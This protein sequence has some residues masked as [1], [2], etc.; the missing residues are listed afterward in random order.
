MF[1]KMGKY[2]PVGLFSITHI[3]SIVIC[4]FLICLV[5]YFTRNMNKKTFSKVLLVTAILLTFLEIFK[6][7]WSFINGYSTTVNSWVPLYFCSLFIYSLWLSQ[8]KNQFIKDIGMSY[9]AFASFI[10]GLVFIFMPTSSFNSYPI[11]H[12]QCLYSMLYHSLMVYCGLMIFVTKSVKINLKLVAKYFIFCF[13]FMIIALIVNFYAGGNLMFISNPAGI[14]LKFLNDI[15]NY[16]PILYTIIM[17]AVHM[18][19]G[20]LIW[21]IN[22]LFDKNPTLTENQT[23]N[24]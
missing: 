13:I 9:I 16:S 4:L 24:T 18:S 3:V 7:I 19:L 22:I 15:Y 5:A 17:M 2:P 10:S 12:F 1:S 20:I 14:P 6:I 21:G 23:S 11:F 8:F